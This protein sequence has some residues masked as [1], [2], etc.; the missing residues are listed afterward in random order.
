LFRARRAA[1]RVVPAR[2][3]IHRSDFFVQAG[4][5]DGRKPRCLLRIIARPIRCTSSHGSLRPCGLRRIARVTTTR[6][7]A[8]SAAWELRRQLLKAGLSV[9]EPDPIRAR[10]AV[11]A[12][13][14]GEAPPVG[15]RAAIH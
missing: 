7:P 15:R 12:C 2:R 11:A 1:G 8:K 5:T 9:W 6:R 14:R 4:T 3:S 13:Q 10:E